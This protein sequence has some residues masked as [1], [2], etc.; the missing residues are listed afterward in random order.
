VRL[1]PEFNNE[2]TKVAEGLDFHARLVARVAKL[3]K[4]TKRRVLSELETY[5]L[6]FKDSFPDQEVSLCESG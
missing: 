2:L 1:N 3:A 5:D 6:G 4:L